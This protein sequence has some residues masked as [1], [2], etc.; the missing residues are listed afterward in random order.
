[1]I[2][3]TILNNWKGSNMKQ[4]NL[5][6]YFREFWKKKLKEI[7]ESSYSIPFLLIQLKLKLEI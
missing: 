2:S 5:K 3:L 1:M 6:M 4:K 7:L